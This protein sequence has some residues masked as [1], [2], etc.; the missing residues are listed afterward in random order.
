MTRFT[1]LAGLG[2]LML[3][4]I[5]LISASE[6]TIGIDERTLSG[7]RSAYSFAD[8]TLRSALLSMKK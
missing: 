6:T 5:S 7:Y 2:I 1:Q 4:S 8:A 3:I